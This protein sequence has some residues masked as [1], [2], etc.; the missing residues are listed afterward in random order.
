MRMAFGL[1][2]L[3]VTVGIIVWIFAEMN[4][5]ISKPARQA[6]DQARQMAGRDETG[7]RAT[8]SL[9]LDL[10]DRGGKTDG[11]IVTAITPGSA[12]QQQYG[13]QVGDVITRAGDMPFG[14]PFVTDVETADAMLLEAY[15]G[16]RPL[17]VVREGQSIELPQPAEVPSPLVESPQTDA[18]QQPPPQRRPTGGLERQREIIRSIPG[19]EPEP[20]Q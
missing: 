11:V 12:L 15:K 18:P 6:Q 13:L 3:L 2:S 14:D 19:Q 1:V 7:E 4:S 17:Q 8:A 10:H 5:G 9:T 20:E 16:N